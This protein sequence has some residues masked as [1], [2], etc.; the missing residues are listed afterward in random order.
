MSLI[1]FLGILLSTSCWIV[2][3]L[4]HVNSLYA[5]E[6]V[7]SD[8]KRII[9]YLKEKNRY[10]RLNKEIDFTRANV[11]ILSTSEAVQIFGKMAD[12]HLSMG[13]FSRSDWL[14]L[15]N[16]LQQ[17]LVFAYSLE[18][19]LSPA[20][21]ASLLNKISDGMTD[22]GFT[23]AY[24]IYGYVERTFD[25]VEDKTYSGRLSAVRRVN[26]G[27][28]FWLFKPC[29]SPY[30]LTI[31]STRGVDPLPFEDKLLE[32][33]VSKRK[34]HPIE[35]EFAAD[36][37]DVSLEALENLNSIPTPNDQ[38]IAPRAQYRIDLRV[39]KFLKNYGH[40]ERVTFLVDSK[41][42]ES[43]LYKNCWPFYR[44]MTL[45]VKMCRE[46]GRL[47]VSTVEVCLPYGS[48]SSAACITTGDDL[49]HMPFA[50][51]NLNP[52][53]RARPSKA[54][55]IAYVLYEDHTLAKFCATEKEVT[56]VFGDFLNYSCGCQI[57]VWMTSEGA[58]SN[59]WK[60]AWFDYDRAS[61]STKIS[62][63]DVESRM[64]DETKFAFAWQ[65]PQ[66]SSAACEQLHTLGAAVQALER[67]MV[68]RYCGHTHYPVKIDPSLAARE[69]DFIYPAKKDRLQQ[70]DE[71]SAYDVLR[72]AC[73]MAGC[74]Y[75]LEGTNVVLT[76]DCTTAEQADRT[77]LGYLHLLEK[78]GFESVKDAEYV[79]YDIFLQEGI[80]NEIGFFLEAPMP[81]CE[82]LL[83][84]TGWRRPIENGQ[85]QYLIFDAC[86]WNDFNL[87][88][89]ALRLYTPIARP[90]RDAAL[91]RAYLR[92]HKKDEILRF[93]NS[94]L[95][96]LM[97]SRLAFAL[98]LMQFGCVESAQQL[99]DELSQDPHSLHR[100]F[101]QLRW[102]VRR[103]RTRYPIFE[104][105][106]NHAKSER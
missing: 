82:Y 63:Y 88:D 39:R 28:E 76:S 36:V 81:R 51:F 45:N 99:F 67:A 79:N 92:E 16:L 43:S 84:G 44:G 13:T 70:T 25:K 8:I 14:R 93:S 74:W 12:S 96:N 37:D 94:R 5:E 24:T 53:V 50:R 10:G 58:N 49:S 69:I 71:L 22:E 33:A 23:G 103:G 75:E 30:V 91:I 78:A 77:L 86:W 27:K 3:G 73:G 57:E 65:K 62:T 47:C 35:M 48:F 61:A 7:P 11:R 40:F 68:C 9:T 95:D 52:E 100:A 102:R 15:Q 87:P 97:A 89:D 59:Y 80:C 105:W 19:Q 1:R 32:T 83:S 31:V 26:Y 90:K 38:S 4:A 18:G 6:Y 20:Q 42:C 29:T 54:V 46:E 66:F 98:H 104:F 2:G 60:N 21:I 34:D 56:G 106:Q 64:D 55:D 41:S 72:L 85:Y 17:G 101:A